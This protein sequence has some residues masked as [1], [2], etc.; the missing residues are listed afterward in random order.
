MEGES[1]PRKMRV[2]FG[3]IPRRWQLPLT[4][5]SGFKLVL[6]MKRTFARN[7]ALLISRPA[8]ST[9]LAYSIS[10]IFSESGKVRCF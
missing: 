3:G 8:S 5:D 4:L 9:G 2:K 10:D 6:V 1:L 7:D